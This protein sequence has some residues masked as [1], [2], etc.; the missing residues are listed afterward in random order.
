MSPRLCSVTL[1]W[2]PQSASDFDNRRSGHTVTLSECLA[3]LF[4]LA[5]FFSLLVA[6]FGARV[7]LPN[8]RRAV[9]QTIGRIF[10]CCRP[11]QVAW[12]VVV[13]R[14]I[15]MCDLGVPIARGRAKKRLSDKSMDIEAA[16]LAADDKSYARIASGVAASL[17]EIAIE[18]ANAPKAGNLIFRGTRNLPPF[19]FHRSNIA[20]ERVNY[21]AGGWQ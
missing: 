8:M 9:T 11:S 13:N 1:V 3:P 7:G 12:L 6:Q 5:D 20:H 16:T 10:L 14:S 15:T 2:R 4:R 21:K 17:A 19:L 18:Q